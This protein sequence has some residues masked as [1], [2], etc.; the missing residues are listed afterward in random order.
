MRIDPDGMLDGWYEDEVGKVVYNPAVNSQADLDRKK[1]SGEY[2][3]QTFVGLDNSNNSY[4][5]NES[6]KVNSL[7]K[8]TKVEEGTVYKS[9]EKEVT[10]LSSKTNRKVPKAELASALAISQVDSP[11]P[12][13]ADLFATAVVVQAII[14][15]FTSEQK[16]QTIS[17]DYFAHERKKQGSGKSGGDRH[18]KQYTHGGKNRVKNPNQRA[19]AENRK[20]KGNRGTR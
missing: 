12:G 14:S 15:Y 1:I 7:S 5:F 2:I 19:G 20:N 16:D 8:E 17:V 18:D 9:V 11:L 13:P 3:A 4:Y 6:G 10:V